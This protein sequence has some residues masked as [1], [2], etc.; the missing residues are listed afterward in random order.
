MCHSSKIFLNAD[1][2]TLSIVPVIFWFDTSKVKCPNEF[3]YF[4]PTVEDFPARTHFYRVESP[5]FPQCS[6]WKFRA[7]RN[8][9]KFAKGTPSF[10]ASLHLIMTA[11]SQG[12][13][14]THHRYPHNL[15]FLLPS[16][17]FIKHT[18]FII[19]IL[20]VRSNLSGSRALYWIKCRKR[21]NLLAM[22]RV[23]YFDFN[24]ICYFLFTFGLKR[25]LSLLVQFSCNFLYTYTIITLC[26]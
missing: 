16:P 14:V 1:V 7:D 2:V 5:L 13:I 26:I 17:T 22:S 21:R 12:S 10:G 23:Y 15:Y 25:C 9:K 6:K 18:L 3:H 19:A 24:I 11:S 20:T 8:W 4:I